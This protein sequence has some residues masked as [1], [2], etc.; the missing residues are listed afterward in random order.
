MKSERNRT[1]GGVPIG[2]DWNTRRSYLYELYNPLCLLAGYA[3]TPISQPE[4][5]YQKL[6]G[7]PDRF[8]ASS[9]NGR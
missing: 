2:A 8:G 4:A 1:F 9:E 6:I 5:E 3:E 7:P